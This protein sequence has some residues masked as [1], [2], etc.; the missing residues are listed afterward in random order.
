MGENTTGYNADRLLC[1]CIYR[2]PTKEKEAAEKSTNQDR[3]IISEAVN[4]H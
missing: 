3:N 2:S 4:K 1:G